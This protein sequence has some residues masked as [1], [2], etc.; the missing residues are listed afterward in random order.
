MKL[1]LLRVVQDT[2]RYLQGF[3]VD[4]IFESDEAEDIAYIAERMYYHLVQRFNNI[5]W[6]GGIGQLESLGDTT[7]PNYMRI[8]ESV[9]RIQHS[10]IQYNAVTADD[11]TTVRYKDVQYV[12]PQ[13]F[14]SIMAGRVDS[15]SNTTTVEDL[16]GTKFVIYNDRAPMYCTTFDQKLIVFDAYDNEVDT[17]L[18][19][20]KSLI[21]F[22]DEATFLIQNSF[23][24]PIP[25]NLS[26]LYQD[27]VTSEASV[28]LRQEPAQEV[29]RRAR[30]AMIRMQ[31]KNRVGDTGF[32]RTYG[33]RK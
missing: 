17:T 22:T 19:Q 3:D 5:Q 9:N 26:T 29:Q 12:S 18:Q 11:T 24:I 6:T 2:S 32:K 4:D 21:H 7:R 10:L 33:R 16:S 23:E 13:D 14:L 8:P 28:Q 31:Q 27:L 20:S 30:A 15:E 25:S 1:T